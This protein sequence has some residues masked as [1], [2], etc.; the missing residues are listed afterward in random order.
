MA[1]EY[2]QNNLGKTQRLSQAFRVTSQYGP[3]L[4]NG[5]DGNGAYLGVLAD[6]QLILETPRQDDDPQLRIYNIVTH[7]GNWIHPAATESPSRNLSVVGRLEYGIGGTQ[8]SVDFDWRT[9]N[10]LSVA[11]SFVRVLAAYST[12][13]ALLAPN[14]VTVGASLASGSRAGRSQATRTF[15]RVIVS[16]AEEGT[17]VFPVP[18]QAHALN[19][20]SEDPEFYE[21][22]DVQIRFLGG[23]N[24][25][26]SAAST[27]DL[28]SFVSDGV[29]FLHALSTEDGVRFPES[30]K[31]IEISTSTEDQDYHI[32]PCFTLNL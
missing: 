3:S 8:F 17:V 5:N 32:T 21:V 24:N 30:V 13:G 20:F 15:P 12:S 4:G 23:A 9:G 6:W 22:G 10:Q 29:P 26:F 19:I 16:N 18:P 1:Q 27:A 28:V 7:L 25:G 11:A 2:Y 31:F 14:E